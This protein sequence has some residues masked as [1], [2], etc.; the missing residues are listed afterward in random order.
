MQELL[1]VSGMRLSSFS[2]EVLLRL[3]VDSML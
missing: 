3:V 1:L 2:A